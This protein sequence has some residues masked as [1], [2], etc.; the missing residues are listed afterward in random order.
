MPSNK[1]FNTLRHLL[2]TGEWKDAL[3]QLAWAF[4]ETV[5]RPVGLTMLLLYLWLQI[6]FQ[7]KRTFWDTARDLHYQALQCVQCTKRKDQK[8]VE[9]LL[10]KAVQKDPSYLPAQLSL[11]A[12][13]LYRLNQTQAAMDL[14][15]NM[16]S[17][18]GPV[19]ALL[20]DAQAIQQGQGHMVQTAMQCDEYLS[21]SFVPSTYPPSNNNHKHK[22]SYEK[23]SSALNDKKNQ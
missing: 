8:Q 7:I 9:T 16:D 18:Q 14:L 20:L 13:Y 17:S 1:L 3:Q 4:W 12:W 21:R 19:Q 23:D 15:S 11:A 2:Q 6:Y 10:K 5:G 22:N